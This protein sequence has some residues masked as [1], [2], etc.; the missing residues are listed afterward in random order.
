MMKKLLQIFL[1][2]MLVF[3][4]GVCVPRSG[5]AQK[6]LY[7]T[8][9]KV[10]GVFFGAWRVESKLKLTDSPETFKTDNVD[11]WNISSEHNV[12]ILRNPFNGAV[13]QINVSGVKGNHV[14]FYKSTR[15][16]D[17]IV[18]DRVKIDIK[19]DY[20]AGLNE[21]KVQTLSGVNGGVIKTEQAVYYLNGERISG[22]DIEI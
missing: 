15:Y 1:V 14:E 18:T 3:I 21:L 17:K 4:S 9:E 22:Q 5:A 19:G 6:V 12:I 16:D 13:G 2:L 7:G 10:P 11:L 20:F 8:V